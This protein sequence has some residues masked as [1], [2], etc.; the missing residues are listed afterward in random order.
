MM[1]A[2]TALALLIVFAA[3]VYVL[4]RVFSRLRSLVVESD[5]ATCGDGCGKCAATHDAPR[6]R[7][8]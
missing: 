3:L 4:R 1:D 5:T 8:L 2:Q 7:E 6:A